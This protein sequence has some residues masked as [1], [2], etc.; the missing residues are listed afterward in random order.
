MGPVDFFEIMRIKGDA[1]RTHAASTLGELSSHFHFL[2]DLNIH[3]LEIPPV[4][5]DEIRQRDI[6]H[7]AVLAEDPH[8]KRIIDRHIARKI[9]QREVGFILVHLQPGLRVRLAGRFRILLV[10][11]R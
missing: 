2:P 7:L 10:Y 1:A 11:G 9:R 5:T 4:S 6:N 3:A 8:P